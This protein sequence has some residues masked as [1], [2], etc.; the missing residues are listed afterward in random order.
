MSPTD[1]PAFRPRLYLSRDVEFDYLSAIEFGSVADGQPDDAWRVVGEQ[2]G[3]LFE[4]PD[5]R[6]TG[7]QVN[8]FSTFDPEAEGFEALWSDT[9]RFDVPQLGLR[10]ASAG[11]ICLAARAFLGDEPTL[12]KCYFDQAVAAGGAGDHSIA[13]GGWQLCLESGDPMAHY[14]LG[15]TLYELGDLRGAY[16]H[17][18]AYVEITPN[19]AWAWC[20]LG[21]AC[22]ELGEHD[23]ARQA[24]E[25]AVELEDH[26]GDE[27]DAP[28]LLEELEGRNARRG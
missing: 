3:F 2:V 14:G 16:R 15:Y 4:E 1:E 19:N 9:P 24:L 8:D 18:R 6:C 7:F 27:T 20:W 11:E 10:G 26:G 12:N 22:L 17:L 28:E 23:E 25:R 5:E 21:R 13:A